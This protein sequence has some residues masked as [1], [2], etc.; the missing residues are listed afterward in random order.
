[1]LVAVIGKKWNPT[2]ASGEPRLNDERDHLRIE[3]ESA[4]QRRIPVIPVLVDG[5]EM[6][7]EKDLPPSLQRLAYYN[8]ISVRPDPDYHNDVTRLARGIEQWLK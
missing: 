5:V 1:M 3:I 6:P 7:S 2:L 4:L 8:G